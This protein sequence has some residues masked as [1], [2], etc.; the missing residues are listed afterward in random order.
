[1]SFYIKSF[2]LTPQALEIEDAV[3][4]K[5][6]F[7]IETD[8]VCLGHQESCRFSFTYFAGNKELTAS[9]KDC[10]N[11][12]NNHIVSDEVELISDRWGGGNASQIPIMVM[13]KQEENGEQK[14]NETY[15]WVEE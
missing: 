14:E 1:M 2:R 6:K 15:T 3:P 10:S 7:T 8:V 13:V 12:D 11:E 4:D 9:I 5:T